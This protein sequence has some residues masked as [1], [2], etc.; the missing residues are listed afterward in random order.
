M[1][2]AAAQRA[3]GILKREKNQAGAIVA[4]VR[5]S[6]CAR[7]ERCISACPYDARYRNEDEDIIEVDLLACQGC[8]S[9]AA[10]CPNGASVVR[11][12]GD[13]QVMAML[14]AALE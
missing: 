1:A 9:C 13:R 3:L 14:D 5:H 7:C 2:Q 12:Y 6:L 10:I 4:E 11:G 8:G